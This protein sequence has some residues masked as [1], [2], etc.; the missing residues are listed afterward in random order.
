MIGNGTRHAQ[1]DGQRRRPSTNATDRGIRVNNVDTGTIQVNGTTIDGDDATA[2]AQGVEI[3]GSNAT[4]T[5]DADTVIQEFDGTDF[6]VDGGTP[7]RSP[8]TATSP[9]RPA[10][11]FTFT[12]SRAAACSS[13]RLARSMTTA[14]ASSSKTTRAASISF[15]GT[16]DLDP[17]AAA[18]EAVLVDNNTGATINFAGL[19]INTVALKRSLSRAR[20][21]PIPRTFAPLA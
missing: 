2:T 14:W 5:F 15:L 17:V 18:T 10:A 9:T 11:R 21:R 20:K 7:E 12:T 6:E 4:I 1:H 8:T 13:R 16:N 19:N 3:I